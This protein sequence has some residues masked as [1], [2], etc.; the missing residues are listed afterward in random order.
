MI[1]GYSQLYICRVCVELHIRPKISPDI[2]ARLLTTVI[3]TLLF[4]VDD[5]EEIE[6]CFNGTTSTDV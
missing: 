6:G 2:R 4:N 1:H 3:N 5:W